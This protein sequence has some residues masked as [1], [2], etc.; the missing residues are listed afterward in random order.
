MHV[1]VCYIY[2]F[3]F[4]SETFD[5]LNVDLFDVISWSV[6]LAKTMPERL[7][8]LSSAHSLHDNKRAVIMYT[9]ETSTAM[10]WHCDYIS[11]LQYSELRKKNITEEWCRPLKKKK[12]LPCY[13][14]HVMMVTPVGM[15]SSHQR[16]W[17]HQK[18]NQC[19]L[20]KRQHRQED[21]AFL[22]I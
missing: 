1:C 6:P 4:F 19:L 13:K 20:S 2:N 7:E 22:K 5:P 18:K 21:G 15:I 10:I 11:F 16:L 17:C 12:T 8:M 9:L 14:G 3:C